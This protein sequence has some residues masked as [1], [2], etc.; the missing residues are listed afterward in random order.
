MNTALIL[1][2]ISDAKHCVK[3]NLYKGNFLFS[4]HSSVDVYLKEVYG[5][6]CQCLSKFLSSEEVINYKKFSSDKVDK[7]LSFLD[8]KVSPVINSQF[9]LEMKYFV[10][11]YSYFGKYQYSGYI[12]FIESLKK[13][14]KIYDLKKVTFY[15]NIFNHFFN[16]STS[17]G[18]FA[19]LIQQSLSTSII[20]YRK[21]NEFEFLKKTIIRVKRLRNLRL[22]KEKLVNDLILKKRFKQFLKKRKTIL[23]SEPLY[24][25]NFLKDALSNYN[26]LFYPQ[27]SLYPV[28]F[29]GKKSITTGENYFQK[30]DLE[31]AFQEPIDQIF[32]KEIKEDFSRNIGDY[33]NAI[34]LLREVNKK[35]PIILGIWGNPPIGKTKALVFEYLKSKGIKILGAQHGA[36]IGN[37]LE[38]WHFD[39]DF[40]RCNYFISYGFTEN[41]LKRLYPNIKLDPKILP[42]GKVTTIRSNKSKKSID[43]LFPL[44]TVVSIFEGGMIR[45][46]PDRHTERQ[47]RLLEY[48]N[49][50]K[51]LKVYIKPVAYVNYENCSVLPVLRRLKNLK[52]VYGKTL[53]EFLEKYNPKVVIIEFPSTPLYE[54]LHLD[55]EIFLMD[56]YIHPFEEKALKEVQRRVHYSESTEEIIS[57]I[58]L[59]LKGKIK[60]KRDDTFYYH[61][62]H[63]KNPKENIIKFIESLIEN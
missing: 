34:D 9:D 6:E 36:V 57:K 33:I 61:Y 29:Q 41:D 7:I 62:V 24:D 59:F 30:L 38:P 47:I 18:Y 51:K 52:V 45:I 32:I 22:L 46:S 16:V 13:I 56:D 4:T 31:K 17:M 1:H 35:Y 50:L 63:K 19:S 48:L 28:G 54:V 12:Y 3:N 5:L 40:K 43:I 8:D 37:A 10:P 14:I 27:N 15:E 58:D 25:L 60:P 21:K 23:L 42:F 2:N 20:C 55:T 49:S 39:S 53:M 26:I 44:N 11:L